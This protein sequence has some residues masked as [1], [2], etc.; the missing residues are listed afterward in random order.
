MLAL[1]LERRPLSYS[2]FVVK[3]FFRIYPAFVVVV[4]SSY[5]LHRLV[6]VT[7]DVAS[8]FLRDEVINPNLSTI[9][10]IKHLALW[11][12]RDG[13]GLDCVIWSL[14]PEMRVSLL[15]PLILIS[16]R[17]YGWRAFAI[18]AVISIASTTL[19]F[20]TTGKISTGSVETT[21]LGSILVSGF[22]IVFFAAGALLCIER[23]RVALAIEGLPRWK[24]IL[25]SIVAGRFVHH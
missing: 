22:F 24:K 12:T 4:L 11:G 3:R 8:Q 9:S 21:T 17:K 1:S 23:K 20:L 13:I 6:G 10:L 19:S 2:A 5:I 18:Y 16:L 15:F 14:V 7:N 25:L